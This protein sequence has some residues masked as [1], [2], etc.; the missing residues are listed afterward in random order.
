MRYGKPS[1]NEKLDQAYD[2]LSEISKRSEKRREKG[3]CG[4]T[5][6]SARYST[7]YL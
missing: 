3:Q 6:R 4:V 5:L 1:I 7:Y 2:S